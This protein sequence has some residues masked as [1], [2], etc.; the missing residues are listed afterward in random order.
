MINKYIGIPWVKG[1]ESLSG[2]DCWGVCR[3][4]MRDVY[5]VE[6][7]N[8]AGCMA[9]GDDLAAIVTKEMEGQDWRSCGPR[10]G[11]LA[12][13]VDKVSKRPEHI[14]VCI[15]SRGLMVLHSINTGPNGASA[16]TPLPVIGRAFLSVRFFEYAGNNS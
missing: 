2:A 3:M 5:G 11:V 7:P 4:V 15:E 10:D 9:E 6:I 14:G 12:V 16:L 8:Q 1:Q 13:M